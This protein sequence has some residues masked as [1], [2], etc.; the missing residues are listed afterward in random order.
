MPKY[1]IHDKK[2]TKR[3]YNK[4]KKQNKQQSFEIIA[5]ND[6]GNYTYRKIIILD[7]QEVYKSSQKMIKAWMQLNAR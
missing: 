7:K 1:L 2:T 6:K 5:Q 4:R 3:L